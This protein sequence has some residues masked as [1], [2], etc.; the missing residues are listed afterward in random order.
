MM[1]AAHHSIIPAQA[2]IEK[3]RKSGIPAFAGMTGEG[4]G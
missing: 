2:G 1:G 4:W 3:T